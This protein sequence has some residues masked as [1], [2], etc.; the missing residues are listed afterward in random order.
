MCCRLGVGSSFWGYST[1][2]WFPW[3]DQVKE[4]HWRCIR[5]NQT[6]VIHAVVNGG[7]RHVNLAVFPV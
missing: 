4:G 2:I 5:V 1:C 3:E 7:I 6:R